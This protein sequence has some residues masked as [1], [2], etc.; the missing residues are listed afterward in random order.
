MEFSTSSGAATGS[1]HDFPGSDVSL[2][3]EGVSSHFF[4]AETSPESDT[5]YL[6]MYGVGPAPW[7]P[8]TVSVDL[9]LPSAS[10]HGQLLS[11]A[12]MESPT[13]YAPPEDLSSFTDE[14][15]MLKQFALGSSV[16]GDSNYGCVDVGRLVHNRQS[17]VIGLIPVAVIPTLEK[18]IP[19]EIS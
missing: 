4:M 3:G 9:S 18:S 8:S 1:S 14:D 10:A 2:N 7:S 6:E 15:G 16:L 5:P 13:I 17:V 11:P 19:V 12:F